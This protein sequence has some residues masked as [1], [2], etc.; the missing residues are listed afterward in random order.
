M[1]DD[2]LK[3]NP[4]PV[5]LSAEVVETPAP[6]AEPQPEP[7]TPQSLQKQLDK[8]IADERYE[9]AAKIR[10]KLKNLSDQ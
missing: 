9:D 5:K 10:D 4:E 2:F 7:E 6:A 3:S 8:A 1:L